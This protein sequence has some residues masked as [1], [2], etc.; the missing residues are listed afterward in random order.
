MI[1]RPSKQLNPAPQKD[2]LLWDNSAEKLTVTGRIT[3]RPD[4]KWRRQML[5]HLFTWNLLVERFRNGQH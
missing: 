1:V 5:S 3:G 4:K 2:L